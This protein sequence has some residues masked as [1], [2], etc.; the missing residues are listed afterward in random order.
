MKN[1]STVKTNKLI[2]ISTIGVYDRL[3]GVYENHSIDENRCDNYGKNRLLFENFIIENFDYHILRLPALFG[4]NIQKGHLYDLIN[5]NYEYLPGNNSKFQYY[6]LDNIWSDIEKCI[7]N[8]I[9]FLNICSEPLPF[10]VVLDMFN[11]ISENSNK[12]IEEDM[13]SVHSKIWNNIDYL[14]SKEYT[15]SEL[16]RFISNE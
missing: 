3:D 16:R 10:K 1:L 11:T 4:D 5:K 14:Y 13:R 6:Y 7:D 2:L 8:D 9:K 15:L 12:I